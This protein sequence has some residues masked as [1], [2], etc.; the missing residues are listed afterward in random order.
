MEFKNRSFSAAIFDMDGLM[1]DTETVF[2]KTW[3]IAAREF[4]Y[5]VT[6]DVVLSA[7]GIVEEVGKLKFIEAYGEDFPFDVISKRRLEIAIDLVKKEGPGV[8]KG[9]YN[10]LAFLREKGLK[11]AV[12]TSSE[13]F[14]TDLYLSM[15]GLTESFDLI[16]C[17]RDET[18]IKSKPAPDIFIE[19]AKRI[20]API[21]QCI[22]FED[23]ENGVKAAAAS[24][25]YTVMIPDKK[26]PTEELRS[27]A[28]VILPDLDDAVLYF[29]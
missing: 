8:K 4:G 24:G 2:L 13:R 16:L 26:Q 17:G 28:N 12:A 15:S 25:G 1:F 10:I 27:L 3:P 5:T 7:I 18:H 19:A 11:L 20:G 22:I 14:R 23:S 6:E 9:L 21:E 29:S